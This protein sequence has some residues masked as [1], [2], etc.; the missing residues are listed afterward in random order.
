MFN[1][2]LLEKPILDRSPVY[3]FFQYSFHLCF[4]Q[5]IALHTTLVLG[6]QS[7]EKFISSSIPLLTV[8]QLFPLLQ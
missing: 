2:A 4:P 7:P 6:P 5:I 3:F 8:N 1:H